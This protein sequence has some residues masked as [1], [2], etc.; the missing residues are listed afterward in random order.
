[1]TSGSSQKT[2]Q[3]TT[4]IRPIQTTTKM[5]DL[6]IN[7]AQRISRVTLR[8]RTRLQQEAHSVP[9]MNWNNSTK[10]TNCLKPNTKK[11]RTWLNNCL[12]KIV[13][14][15]RSWMTSNIVTKEL[16]QRLNILKCSRKRDTRATKTP[17]PNWAIRLWCSNMTKGKRKPLSHLTVS[18]FAMIRATLL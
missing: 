18:R 15:F 7:S 12:R 13:C 17:S 1:M 10:S 16:L 11:L 4:F 9:T 8:G 2:T 6:W 5:T 3:S 14:R